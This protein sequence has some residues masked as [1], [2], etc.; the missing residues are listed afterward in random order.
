[1]RGG[2]TRRILTLIDLMAGYRRYYSVAEITKSFN[3]VTNSSFCE[4]TIRR[5]LEAFRECGIVDTQ[6]NAKR[7]LWRLNIHRT[8]PAQRVAIRLIDG[9]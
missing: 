2:I 5:D 9:H 6:T 3:E 4:R 1:M 7:V 8:E